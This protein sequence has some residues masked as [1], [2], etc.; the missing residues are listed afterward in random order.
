MES[1]KVNFIASLDTQDSEE[2]QQIANRLRQKGCR[3]D[4]ILTFTGIITGQSPGTE[5]NLESLKVPGVKYI[6][7]DGEVRAL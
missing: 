3:I 4:R 5:D 2:M 1:K 7:E 6:E